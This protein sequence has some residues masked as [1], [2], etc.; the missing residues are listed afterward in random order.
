MTRFRRLV[1]NPSEL[2]HSYGCQAHHMNL[3]A[4]EFSAK[5]KNPID[6]I[7]HVI[8]HLR[9]YHAESALR[10][11]NVPRLPLPTE[12]RWNSV[13]ETLQFFIEHWS[14][15]VDV[16][17]TITGLSDPIYRIMQDIQ[18]KRTAA[19]LLEIFKPLGKALDE[20]QSD[21]FFIGECYQIWYNLR[22][23][24]PEQFAEITCKRYEKAVKENP[25]IFAAN[26]LDHRFT[27][28]N[29]DTEVVSNALNY[30]KDVDEQIV[31]EVTKFM[32]KAPPYNAAYFEGTFKDA[33]PVS[34]W[35]SGVKM[36]F[37]QN[38]AKIAVSL[39]SAPSSSG[40]L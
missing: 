9:L 25:V 38:L 16:V 5:L 26:L 8:K 40:G 14:T 4:K 15:L 24:A 35:K 3:V 22:N 36:G 12:T 39:V 20:L 32:S 29:L 7:L 37:D 27:G 2:M 34:W 18:L 17:N 21:T 33:D 28:N 6:R 1:K 30:I 23:K 11:N 31:L 19:D 13:S 10:Q